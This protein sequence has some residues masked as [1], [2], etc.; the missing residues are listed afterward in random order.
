MLDAVITGAAALI[1]VA[2]ALWWARRDERRR[3][4][5]YHRARPCL[6]CADTGRIQLVAGTKPC[7]CIAGMAYRALQQSTPTPGNARGTR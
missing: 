6:L 5:H 7:R 1:L 3:R 4:R 2:L